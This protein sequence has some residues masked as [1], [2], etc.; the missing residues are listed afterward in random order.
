MYMKKCFQFVIVVIFVSILKN[1]EGRKKIGHLQARSHSVK[2]SVYI[3]NKDQI[4]V[5]QFTFVGNI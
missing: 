4:L 1:V 5:Q 3:L 2:G